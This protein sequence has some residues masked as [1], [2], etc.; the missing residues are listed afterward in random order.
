MKK[1][2]VAVIGSGHLGKIHARIYHQNKSVKLEGICDINKDSAL[3]FAEEFNTKAFFDY[4][5]LLDKVTAVSIATPTE[6]H[7]EIAKAFLNHKIHVMVEKPIT[8]NLKNAQKLIKL[9][10]KNNCIL[11]VG[12]VERFNPA[13]RAINKLCIDPKFIECHRLSPYPKRSTDV[14]VVLDLMIHDLDI[15]LSLVKSPLKNFMLSE[16]MYFLLLMTLL[17]PV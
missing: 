15:V 16:L 10:K 14:S 11:Q 12:H 1:I 2:K 7:Y 6:T 8:N 4:K 3:K 13:I 5:E 17:I 9:A